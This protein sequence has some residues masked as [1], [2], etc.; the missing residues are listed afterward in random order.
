MSETLVRT[1]AQ[2]FRPRARIIRTLGR[3]LIA[4]EIIAMQELIKNA[5]DADA[6]V[7]LISFIP[8][9]SPGSGEI[10]IEDD[11]EGMSLETLQK[12]WMEPA[13]LSKVGRTHSKKLNRRVTGEKGIGRFASARIAEVLELT[14][15]SA[16]TGRRV[17]ARFDWGS[18]DDETQYLDEIKCEW[19]EDDPPAG[20]HAGTRL[21]LIG[22]HD[23]WARDKGQ[24]FKDL[25]SELSRLVSP[26]ARPDFRIELDVPTPFAQFSGEVAPPAFLGKPRYWITGDV[27]ETGELD[28][29][30]EG[31]DGGAHQILEKNRP[32]RIK[33]TGGRTPQCGPIKFELRVWDRATDD[34]RPLAAEFNS[35]LR[36]IRRDLDAASGI[37]I[38][39]DGF[40]VLLPDSDW[41]RLDLR[42]VQNPTL[43]LSNNQIVGVISISR[44]ANPQL[45]DQTN[46]QGIVDSPAFE[47]FKA[48]VKDVLSRL[49]TQ[50][51]LVR[52]PD[53]EKSTQH[54]IFGH[55]DISPLR[56]YVQEKYS[57]DT[58]LTKLLADTETSV[59]AGV[60]EVKVVLARY[61]RL[62]T[63]GQLVDGILHEGRTPISAI[64]NS[65]MFMRKDLTSLEIGRGVVQ[66]RE[67]IQSR[68]I[69]IEEQIQRLSDMFKRI[70][71]F[72]GRKPGRPKKTTIERMLADIVALAHT[73]IEGLGVQVILPDGATTVTLD[74]SEMQSLFYNLL[75]NALYWLE[76]VPEGER[77]IV[78]QVL[79]SP[80]QIQVV[81]S[82]SG[83]GVDEDV[84][85]RIFDPYFSTKADG[86]GLGLALAGEIAAEHDGTLELL[87][88]GPLDGATF[89][90]TLRHRIEIK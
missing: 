63:L 7:C 73:Q 45:T 60:G 1:G 69:V 87:A 24:A 27:D 81:F 80:G 37:R 55:F 58:A 44:D 40:R 43:R 14:S 71:P 9:L 56:T 85:S 75:E 17:Q 15:V 25:K 53:E 67:K 64:S 19:I 48:A 38:Y 42:R 13:T 66:V 23:E 78:I 72:S 47:D 6:S 32:P 62:A 57:Q 77:K 68:L 12:A 82:D 34:L 33:L 22:L 8:P 28:A 84:R 10:V 74:A 61:R 16:T 86:I 59:Q 50:R 83:P 39:R 30:Y 90:V 65:V 41:L 2:A 5:Y 3:E 29:V 51:D 11:G 4:N 46:R 54:G 49:E 35:T 20:S 70:A 52:R 76:R 26:I 79:S 21:R 18:F 89:R 31:P 88:D 36:D